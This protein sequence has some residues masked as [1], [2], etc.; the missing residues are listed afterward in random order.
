MKKYTK[1]KEKVMQNIPIIFLALRR[2]TLRSRYFEILLYILL[3][4]APL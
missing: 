2:T 4:N 1:E 3:Q